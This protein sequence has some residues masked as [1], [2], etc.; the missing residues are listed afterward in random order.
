MSGQPEPNGPRIPKTSPIPRLSITVVTRPTI[1]IVCSRSSSSGSEE[2][3]IAT[4]PTPG[5]YTMLNWP[6]MKSKRGRAA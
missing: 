3:E 4:S 2:I 1:R 5:T 6:G